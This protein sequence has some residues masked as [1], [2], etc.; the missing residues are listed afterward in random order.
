MDFN[1]SVKTKEDKYALERVE[2]L[3][4]ILDILEVNHKIPIFFTNDITK[5]KETL[6]KEL[7]PMIKKYFACSSWTYFRK[8]N[9]IVSLIKSVI[10]HLGYKTQVVYLMDPHNKKIQKKGYC[11]IG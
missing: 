8:S 7:E 10:H 11:I 5:E 1:K 2:I 3:N 6:I 4:E 9:S